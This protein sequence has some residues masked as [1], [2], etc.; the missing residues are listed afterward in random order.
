MGFGRRIT[1]PLIE[2][3]HDHPPD[4]GV[5]YLG[6]TPE[7]G[8]EVPHDFR[9]GKES[10]GGA[11]EDALPSSTEPAQGGGNDL[12]LGRIVSKVVEEQILWQA[13]GGIQMAKHSIKLITDQLY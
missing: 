11:A 12:G 10:A 6:G 3:Q 2:L 8:T 5:V 9:S 7:G 4:R 13:S 1:G